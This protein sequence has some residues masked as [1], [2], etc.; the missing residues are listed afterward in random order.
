MTK[1]FNDPNMICLCLYAPSTNHD[2]WVNKSE[3]DIKWFSFLLLRP[4]RH[5]SK[6]KTD[7][8]WNADFTAVTITTA[9]NPCCGKLCSYPFI[10]VYGRNNKMS[11]RHSKQEFLNPNTAAFQNL[12]FLSSFLHFLDPASHPFQ[13]HVHPVACWRCLFPF[14]FIPSLWVQALRVL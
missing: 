12:S 5:G 13:G 1:I 11:L 14:V 9:L 6:R 10:M 3:S 7:D 2:A 8:G 4:L